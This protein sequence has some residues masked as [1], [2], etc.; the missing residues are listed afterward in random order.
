MPIFKKGGRN[1]L[2]IHIPKC[3]GTS[4]TEAFRDMGY[5]VLLHIG[6][7]PPQEA[8][9]AS[10]QHLTC[11]DLKSIIRLDEIDEIFTVVR[12]PYSRLFS[13]YKWA[14]RGMTVSSD[15]PPFDQWSVEQ[16]AMAKNDPN[17]ADNH[18]RPMVDFISLDVPCKIFYY[19][20]GLNAIAEF[21]SEEHLLECPPMGEKNRAP[22]HLL[23]THDNGKAPRLQ[24]L[25]SESSLSFINNYYIQD[26]IAFSY[27][28]V[29]SQCNIDDLRAS[30]P[31]FSCTNKLLY[32]V[33]DRLAQSTQ[34]C[35][36]LLTAKL[37]NLRASSQHIRQQDLE[38]FASQISSAR[39]DIN[40]LRTQR[41]KLAAESSDF[42]HRHD[43]LLAEF[44]RLKHDYRKLEDESQDLKSQCEQLKAVVA[45]AES[46]RHLLSDARKEAAQ[47]KKR[48]EKA[49]EELESNYLLFQDSRRKLEYALGKL[50]WNRDQLKHWST[51]ATSS[52]DRQRRMLNLMNRLTLAISH[53]I[54]VD[55]SAKSP[56]QPRHGIRQLIDRLLHR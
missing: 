1:I 17:H 2:Y 44:K 8:L 56:V 5:T 26:F 21:Y 9:V 34:D 15:I 45:D 3:G 27:P 33:G 24:E 47:T 36:S 52:Y 49:L 41:D 10:P 14:T 42:K 54:Q 4:I 40:H 6:G 53:G 37:R 12:N 48:L 22:D 55:S 31:Q 18:I 20:S 32:E 30:L 29:A 46:T 51:L 28:L 25:L 13:E 50:N 7:L 16:I 23:P 35:L 11:A 38:T 19:E 43:E 39:Q